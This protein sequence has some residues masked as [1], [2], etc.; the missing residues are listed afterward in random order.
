MK[1]ASRRTLVQNFM[2]RP[3]NVLLCFGADRSM[4][5]PSLDEETDVA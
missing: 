4:L 1:G 2:A 3:P 5:R